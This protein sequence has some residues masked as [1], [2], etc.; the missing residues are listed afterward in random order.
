MLLRLVLIEKKTADKFDRH[1]SSTV[2]ENA[3]KPVV[4]EVVPPPVPTDRGSPEVPSKR[5]P[6]FPSVIE[7]L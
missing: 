3:E 5:K 2:L 4:T 6:S 7:L 1:V